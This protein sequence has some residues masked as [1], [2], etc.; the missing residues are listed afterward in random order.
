MVLHSPGN[1]P[2][3]LLLHDAGS[4]PLCTR[5]DPT[6]CRRSLDVDMLTVPSHVLSATVDKLRILPISHL[7]H[8][9]GRAGQGPLFPHGSD[10]SPAVPTKSYVLV[11]ST[12]RPGRREMRMSLAAGTQLTI[13]FVSFLSLSIKAFVFPPCWVI[14]LLFNQVDTALPYLQSWVSVCRISQA[15]LSSKLL[16]PKRAR[17]QRKHNDS[18]EIP[19]EV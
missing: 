7:L 15:R 9:M 14:K 12:T 16:N 2:I 3:I 18:I 6:A 13:F 1:P 5:G 19:C 10:R 11:L 17:Y 4:H 8:P